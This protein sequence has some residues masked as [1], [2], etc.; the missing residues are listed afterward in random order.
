MLVDTVSMDSIDSI[1][2][3]HT[4]S[5][6]LPITNPHTNTDN[7]TVSTGQSAKSSSTNDHNNHNVN[8]T[9]HNSNT[10]LQSMNNTIESCSNELDINMIVDE[11]N[12]SSSS[13]TTDDE[14]SSG[15]ASSSSGSS[16]GGD[17]SDNESIHSIDNTITTEH[18]QTKK[19]QFMN[20]KPHNKELQK[21]YI[22][23]IQHTIQQSRL[24]CSYIYI[25]IYIVLFCCVLHMGKA[26]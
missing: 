5:T 25:Y 1:E 13:T 14:S 11:H 21:F 17:S 22:D 18:K 20:Y 8:P 10:D 6:T 24:M 12:Q 9:T 3:L 19:L 4:N 15:T 16:S 23:Q 7:N 26:I 2:L